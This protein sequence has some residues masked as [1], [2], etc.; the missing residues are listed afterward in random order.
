MDNGRETEVK[1]MA[2]PFLFH[3][4]P[5]VF[6]E[7]IFILGGLFLLESLSLGTSGLG[8]SPMGTACVEQ[9]ARKFGWLVLRL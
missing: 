3:C 8:T 1:G 5:C 2:C 7:P 6:L 9:G 4:S